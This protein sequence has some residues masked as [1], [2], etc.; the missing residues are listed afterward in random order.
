MRR[1][2][3]LVRASTFL[4][5]GIFAGMGM[6]FRIGAA[7]SF[8]LLAGMAQ[9]V[10]A[11]ESSSLDSVI[12]ED[13]VLSAGLKIYAEQCLQCH[14]EKGS[15][16]EDYYPDPL[17]GDGS[18]GELTEII[19]DTMPE[20]DPDL[21]VGEDAAAVAAYIHHAFYSEAAQIRNRPPRQSLQ[22]LTGT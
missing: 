15:G 19:V 21:C 3:N 17:V 22:R 2:P 18:I 16:T 1:I 12:A 5:S 20:E 14:G 6:S 4:C 10:S 11:A 13:P 7:A 8:A 9:P